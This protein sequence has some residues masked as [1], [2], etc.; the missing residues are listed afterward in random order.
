MSEPTLPQP[1]STKQ[2][3]TFTVPHILKS[4]SL[5][6]NGFTHRDVREGGPRQIE[7]ETT[8][9]YS[10]EPVTKEDV[11]T[12]KATNQLNFAGSTIKVLN[13]EVV[14]ANGFRLVPTSPSATEYLRLVG[15][16]QLVHFNHVQVD[17]NHL[18]EDWPEDKPLYK[19]GRIHIILP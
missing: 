10:L 4:I 11:F 8:H 7:Y 9:E 16:K 6:E 2:N 12:I 15:T 14:L 17:K 19:T 5:D 13:D 18:P 1:I 3:L